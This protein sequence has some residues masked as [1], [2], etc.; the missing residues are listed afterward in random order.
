M[1]LLNDQ[2][3]INR[4]YEDFSLRNGLWHPQG[5]ANLIHYTDGDDTETYLSQVLHDAKDLSSCSPELVLAIRDW[6]SLYHLSSERANLLRGLQ[7][8]KEANILELGSG[9]GALTRYLAENYA[10]V[11]AIEGS[12]IRAKLTQ[13]RCKDLHNVDVIVSN[14]DAVSFANTFDVVTLVGVLEYATLFWRGNGNPYEQLLLKSFDMLSENGVLI[15]SIENKFGIKYF[16]G[17]REDHLNHLFVGI[18]GYP[19][20]NTVMTFSKY[21]LEAMIRKAGFRHSQFLLPFPDYKIVST[22][23]NSEYTSHSSFLKYNLIDWCRQTSQDYSKERY[24]LFNEHLALANFATS[25]LFTNFANS[26]LVIAWKNYTP[27]KSSVAKVRWIAQKFNTMRRAEYQTSTVLEKNNSKVIIR[28]RRLNDNQLSDLS[29]LKH[30]ITPESKY[31]LGRI[32][33]SY[34]MLR[35]LRQVSDAED[36]F[37]KVI[38]LWINFLKKKTKRCDNRLPADY[39]D[40]IPDNLLMDEKGRLKYIDVEWRWSEPVPLDWVILRGLLGFW[41]NYKYW[42]DQTLMKGNYKFYEFINRCLGHVDMNIEQERLLELIMLE[43]RL[44]EMVVLSHPL[45]FNFLL[46][47]TFSSNETCLR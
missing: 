3:K 46:E 16:S 6:P 13:L 19:D 43:K 38:E 15:L 31:L 23:I 33:L 42:I 1:E 32:S 14:I 47:T 28:K 17:C 26:F 22:V 8:V 18:E 45:D 44:Q 20:N 30:L 24:Y 34:L 36:S 41:L 39:L 29:L 27:M 40:C 2:K 4:F 5:E 11:T 12:P 10:H 35:A 9:C 37:L 7:I 21:E 25:N